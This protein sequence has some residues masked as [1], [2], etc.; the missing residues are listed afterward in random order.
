MEYYELIPRVKL[1][2]SRSCPNRVELTTISN[3][4]TYLLLLVFFF[5]W[6]MNP[7]GTLSKLPSIILQILLGFHV[8]LP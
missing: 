3:G 6:N 7:Q 4:A 8:K 5:F 2:F 1:A